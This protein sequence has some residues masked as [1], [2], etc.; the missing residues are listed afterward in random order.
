LTGFSFSH[1]KNP[2][3]KIPPFFFVATRNSDLENGNKFRAGNRRKSKSR[4]ESQN[5]F[6]ANQKAKDIFQ[7]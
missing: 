4:N 6:A 7:K 5:K 1:A 3:L 2:R